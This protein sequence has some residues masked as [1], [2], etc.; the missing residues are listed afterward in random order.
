M[1]ISNIKRKTKKGS[2]SR[3]VELKLLKKSKVADQLRKTAKELKKAKKTMKWRKRG[4]TTIGLGAV[5]GGGVYYSKRADE[6][7]QSL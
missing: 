4:A 7:G 3:K 5:G 2:L 1:A 6:K